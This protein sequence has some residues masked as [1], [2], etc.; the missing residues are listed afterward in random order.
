[1]LILHDFADK[2]CG[3]SKEY[4]FKKQ[5]VLV[6]VGITVKTSAEDKQKLL[7]KV[8]EISE[9]LKSSGKLR[10]ECDLRDNV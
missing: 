3:F 9:E 5:I 1:M 8:K 10:V 6:P 4:F 2:T 7:D